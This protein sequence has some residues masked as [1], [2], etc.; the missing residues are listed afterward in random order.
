[1]KI[2]RTIVLFTSLAALAALTAFAPPAQARQ[3]TRHARLQ[4]CKDKSSGDACTYT[5]K[6]EDVNGTCES[7]RHNKLI[8][9]AAAGGAMNAPAGATGGENTGATGGGDGAKIRALQCA[10]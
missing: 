7:G 10:A 4:A 9:T 8:C 3:S 2:K 5:H 1:M 6:G